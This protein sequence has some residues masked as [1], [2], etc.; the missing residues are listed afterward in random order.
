[1]RKAHIEVL[2]SQDRGNRERACELYFREIQAMQSH[3]GFQTKNLHMGRDR[4]NSARAHAHGPTKGPPRGESLG[5]FFG[6]AVSCEGY[7]V[8]YTLPSE[9]HLS[10]GVGD[11]GAVGG[12][13][14]GNRRN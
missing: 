5:L 9:I 12:E 6:W 4:G 3:M 10:L 13:G 7:A 11:R 1:M 8:R 14:F 2:Q